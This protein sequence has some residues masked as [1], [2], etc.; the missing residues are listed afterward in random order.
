MKKSIFESLCVLLFSPLLIFLEVCASRWSSSR[1]M[2]LL[3]VLVL[4]YFSLP[5]DFSC[6][7]KILVLTFVRVRFFLVSCCC[8]LD[9]TSADF[10]PLVTCL[11]NVLPLILFFFCA[12]L[13]VKVWR[14]GFLHKSPLRLGCRLRLSAAGPLAA[15]SPVSCS[16]K[17]PIL[18]RHPVPISAFLLAHFLTQETVSRFAPWPV[19]PLARTFSLSRPCFRSSDR[20]RFWLPRWCSCQL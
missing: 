20:A 18:P 16:F 12:H 4:F 11:A 19:F 6:H 1:A 15:A 2:L 8:D 17:P 9:L 5:S 3:A 13:V 14:Q 10:V 7:W